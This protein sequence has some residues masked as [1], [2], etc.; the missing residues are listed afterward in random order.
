[1]SVLFMMA[2][3]SQRYLKDNGEERLGTSKSGMIN[4]SPM[5]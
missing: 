1:M 3:I 4:L 2:N 5:I